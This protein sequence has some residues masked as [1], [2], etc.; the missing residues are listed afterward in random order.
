MNEPIAIVGMAGRFPGADDLD[1]LWDLLISGGTAIRSVPAQRWDVDTP[2]DGAKRVP[3]MGGFL[4]GI[5][6]FD[7]ALFGISPREARDIDPQQRLMLETAWRAL[8]DAGI[9]GHTLRGTRTGVYIGASWHDYETLRKQRGIAATQHSLVGTALDVIAARLSYRLGLTGP[10]LVVET[11]CSSALVALDLAVRAIRTGDI[12]SAVVG[13][14]NLI[15][16]P[17]ISIGL[18][19]FGALSSVGRC[20]AFGA[21]ADGFVRGEGVAAVYLKPL[22]AAVRDG[23][24]VRALITATVVNNDGGGESLV[25]PNDAG[26]RDLLH[27][28]YHNVGLDLDRL[29]YVE[30]HGTGTGRGDP[31]EA[32]AIGEILARPRG[33]AVGPLPIGSIKTNIGHLE[34]AAGIA[35]LIKGV[36][37]LERGAIPPSLHARELNPEIAFDALNVAVVRERMALPEAGPVFLGVNSFGWGGT[38]AHAVLSRAELTPHR[39]ASPTA[40]SIAKCATVDRISSS[41]LGFV[42][43]SAH[44]DDALRQRCHDI[45]DLLDADP[46]AVG[47]VATA[48]ARRA[49]Q[50]PRRIA[51]IGTEPGRVTAELRKHATSATAEQPA[52]LAGRIREAGRVAFVFPG[53]GAQWHGVGAALYGTDP[54]FTAMVD[55]CAAALAPHVDW[56][57][58]AVIAGA[59]GPDWLDHVDQVQ[60]VLWALSLGIAAM[61]RSMGI[62]ADLVIGHSQGEIAA[63]TLAGALGLTDGALIVARRSAALRAVAGSGRMLAVEL[64][65]NEIPSWIDGFEDSVTLA[66]HNGPTSCVLAGDTDSIEALHEILSADGVFCRIVAVDYASHGPHMNRLRPALSAALSGVTSGPGSVEMRSTVTGRLCEPGELGGDYWVENICCPVLFADTMASAFDSGVTHVIEISPHPVLTPAI[67][68]LAA[69]RSNPPVVVPSLYRDR[70][71][72]AEMQRS[73][74]RAYLS[75]LHPFADISGTASVTLPPYPMQRSSFWLPAAESGGPQAGGL[76][77]PVYPSVVEI[78]AWHANTSIALNHASWLDDHRVGDA[79]VVPAAMMMAFVI[80]VART[81]YGQQPAALR[82]VRFT[83]ALA[84]PAAPVRLDVALREDIAGGASFELRSLA[85]TAESW[86]THARGQVM[87]TVEPVDMPELPGDTQPEAA[88]SGEAVPGAAVS[89]ADFYRLCARRGLNYGPEFQGVRTIQPVDGGVVATIELGEQCRAQLYRGELHTALI[90]SAMQAALALFDDTRTVVPVAVEELR[91]YAEPDEFIDTARVYAVRRSDTSADIHLFDERRTPLATIRGLELAAIDDSD[92]PIRRFD[93]EFRFVLRAAEADGSRATGLEADGSCGTGADV[94]VLD[95]DATW[96]AALAEALR[97][98]GARVHTG[99]SVH[100]GGVLVYCVSAGDLDAQRDRLVALADVVRAGTSTGSTPLRLVVMTVHAQSATPDDRPD[101]GSAMFWGFVRVLRREHPELSATVVDIAG[102]H[103]ID[104]CAAELLAAPGEDQVVLRAGRRYIGRLEQGEINGSAG[105]RPWRAQ[106]CP[107]RLQSATGRHWDGLRF[108]P[109]SVRPPGP[110]EVLV[111]IDAAAVN[112]IDVMKAAGTYPDSSAG[113]GEFGVEGAGVV[114]RVGPGVTNR[115]VGD[116]VIA[117]GFGAIGS[118]LTVRADHTAPIPA[119]MTVENAAALPMVTTT[120]WYALATLGRVAPGETVLIHSGTGGLGLAAIGIARRLGARVLAT[121]GSAERRDYLRRVH[122]IDHVFDSRGLTWADEVRAATGGRGVDVVLNSLSGVAIDL[123]LQLLAEDGRFLEV[124]KKDIY[125]NRWLGS[126]AFTKGIGFLAVDLAGMMIRRPDRFAA[127]LREAWQLILDGGLTPLPTSVHDLAEA[128][129]VLRRM[130]RGDHIGKFVLSRPATVSRIVP[131]PMPDGRFRAD[132]T[133]LVTGGHGALG[134]SLA[135]WLLMHGAGRVVLVGRSAPDGPIPLRDFDLELPLHQRASVVSRRV[136]V[137]DRESLA[138]VLDSI[139]AEAPPLRGIFHAAGILDDATVLGL[140]AGQVERVLR[141][142]IDGARHLDELTADDPLDL[143]V[144]F[145]SA[146]ALIG[147]PGQSAYA[148]A[149]AYLDALAVARRHDGRPGLSIQWGPFAEI[150]L[151]AAQDNRGTRLA[152]HGMDSITAAEAWVALAG[153]L[154]EDR[155]VVSYLSFD[156]RRWFD[157]YPDCAA[158]PSWKALRRRADTGGKRMAVSEFRSALTEVAEAERPR[159]ILGKVVEIAAGVLRMAPE[160]LDTQT[161]L[162]AM[163]LD[164]LMSLELRNKLESNFA[165]RLSPTL[166]WTYGTAEALA[167]ALGDQIAH[168]HGELMPSL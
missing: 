14:V 155:Q 80:A 82:V 154:A 121:A 93:R 62:V 41:E 167:T 120:A 90:D 47:P 111:E 60:P 158:Q 9:P 133:Y 94:V 81:R 84:L 127:A 112:F 89:G 106:H 50:L 130:A 110:G 141:P 67:E 30:A 24:R 51:V 71:P 56:D 42:P 53:Q 139:R 26:Q 37:C 78:G 100:A 45:A 129:E 2:L 148:A 149:N 77:V 168:V 68:Q 69:T 61:W 46:S 105:L 11:G 6:E 1:A 135:H 164:S 66:V 25:T 40:G 39:T 97:R 28:A 117:C 49:H 43:I 109:L 122:G 145:S 21:G 115:A 161:P 157:A 137:S 150:G 123:G 76:R 116:R 5:D 36:L 23:D 63:A 132:G 118:H 125:A 75:G 126:R 16:A 52:V 142:K 131:E 65:S 17:D 119:E 59:A 79:V 15:L 163:G 20:A 95:G 10:S 13:G 27:R 140:S 87:H 86:T 146:A 138:V 165:L 73:R 72:L 4:D 48:L 7:A 143:F 22:R 18:T 31:I 147:N 29:A 107:F 19:H 159:L 12:E 166:L 162:R 92:T 98:R 124:G 134:R 8:E 33:S 91:L 34:A 136:D 58:L 114:R 74:A 88:V 103:E 3:A 44:T 160:D 156:V 70:D 108:V 38:N 128:P 101:P 152:A 83:D 99:G 35:G 55:E 102:V 104:D 64:A 144:L 96:H 113:A 32:R 54:A 153:F 151:A 57:P 85:E